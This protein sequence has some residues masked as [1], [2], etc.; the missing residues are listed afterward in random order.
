MC[1]G[2]YSFPTSPAFLVCVCFSA[3]VY[4]GAHCEVPHITNMGISKTKAGKKQ[5][6]NAEPTDPLVGNASLMHPLLISSH[7]KWALACSQ[8][9]SITLCRLR[10][11]HLPRSLDFKDS[12]KI[13]SR[14]SHTRPTSG[15]CIKRLQVTWWLGDTRFW[16]EAE[17]R[18]SL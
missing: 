3:V 18:T 7:A 8:L 9:R 4:A 10:N 11:W 16:A 15:K 1:Q 17:P 12:C 6:G 14:D 13:V 5:R 2:R